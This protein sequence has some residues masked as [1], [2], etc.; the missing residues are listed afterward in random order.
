MTPGGHHNS[1]M[2]MHMLLI[3]AMKTVVN[4]QSIIQIA[5]Q[6]PRLGKMRSTPKVQTQCFKSESEATVASLP[7]VGKVQDADTE[8]RAVILVQYSEAPSSEELHS[9]N[10]SSGTELH[11]VDFD[12]IW[13]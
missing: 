8:E 11:H 4:V 10:P 6:L 9:G 3:S 13:Q 2:V 1:F 7:L 12:S 5:E